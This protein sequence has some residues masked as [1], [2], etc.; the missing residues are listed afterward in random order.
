MKISM[1]ITHEE[2]KKMKF[3]WFS[4]NTLRWL[5]K[6]IPIVMICG[7]IYPS[8]AL[9]AEKS[10]IRI[11][12]LANRG[13]KL[14]T[15]MWNPTA[16][17]LSKEIPDVI[18]NIVPLL[19]EEIQSAVSK[20]EIDFILTNPANYVGL[21]IHHG[22]TRISTLKRMSPQ[23][24]TMYYGGVIIYKAGRTDLKFLKDLK[25][26]SFI[27]TNMDSFGG[28]LAICLELKE[29]GIDPF[30]FFSSIQF[31]NSH[32][33][34]I[35]AIKNGQAD[36]GGLRT[37]VLEDLTQKGIIHLNDFEFI[38]DHKDTGNELPFI[39]STRAYPEWA[40]AKLPHVQNDLGEKVAIALMRMPP[41][42][43]A[44][45]AAGCA[46]W[47]IPQNYQ[48]VHE[49]LKKLQ[50]EPYENFGKVSLHDLIERY[51]LLILVG[52]AILAGIIIFAG[53]TYRLNKKLQVSLTRE[54][55]L[56]AIVN[57]AEDAIIGI[58]KDGTIE[59]C[60]PA[61]FRMF[62]FTDNQL[63]GTQ[64]SMRLSHKEDWDLFSQVF[65]G[66]PFSRYETEMITSDN[67]YLPVSLTV[68]PIKDASGVIIGASIIARDI[69][70]RKQS[71]KLLHKTN[72]AL[73][74]LSLSN[75]A[76][77]YV[78]NEQNLL[79]TI[80]NIIVETGKYRMARVGYIDVTHG[81]RRIRNVTF[82]GHNDGYIEE[83][84]SSAISPEKGFGPSGIAIQTGKPYIVRNI[85]DDP[86]FAP[87]REAALKRGYRSV[88]ALPLQDSIGAFGVLTIYSEEPDAF[89]DSEYRLLQDLANN[90]SFGIRAIR[91]ASEHKKAEEGLKRLEAAIEQSDDGI[92]IT[93][94][95]GT[96]VYVNPAFERISGYSKQE[97]IGQNPRILKSNKQS[98]EFYKTMWD[99]ITQ[100]KVWRSRYTNK[101]KDGQLYETETS[102]SP[103]FDDSGKIINYVSVSRDITQEIMMEA[104]LRQ[105]QKMEAIGTL[106]GGIAHDF[107]NIL[108]PIFGYAQMTLDYLPPNSVAKKNLEKLLIAAKRAKDLVQQ[109]LTF[110]RK[111]EQSRQP[112]KI[113]FILKESLKLLRSVIPKTISI[114]ETIDTSCRPV[115][116]DA[117]QIH[118]VILNLCTNAYHAMRDKGGVLSVS[119]REVMLNPEDLATKPGLTPGPYVRLSI[120]DTG[121]GIDPAI[122]DKIFDPFFTTKPPGEGTGM[123][124]SVA[125]GIVKSHNG[126]ISVYSEYGIGSTFS[127]YL[128]CI[129]TSVHP[130]KADQAVELFRGSASIMIVD[131]EESIVEML[132]E[133]LEKRGFQ[134][135]A[136]TSS[137]EALAIFQQSPD[138]FDIVISDQTMPEMTGIQLVQNLLKIKPDLPIILCTGFSESI[139]E[140]QVKSMGVR[141]FIMKPVIVEDIIRAIKKALLKPANQPGK[142]P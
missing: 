19:Y 111:D 65:E 40:F 72:R 79:E 47:T 103:V 142:D 128:P 119:F 61:G 118:Q 25:Q 73:M 21:E 4:T 6:I 44:S 95:Q 8:D 46:G 30:K 42:S 77:I 94:A 57:S 33:E 122:K 17:Y 5:Y 16:E 54:S 31:V 39:H 7:L 100:G 137:L 52:F 89:D 113:Q 120:S 124:L 139:T 126:F 117:T 23:G 76:L 85:L 2:V 104:Q 9:L 115:M 63:L 90:L 24:P 109:I 86:N 70:L 66:L 135:T 98:P 141:E 87:W 3:F 49:C 83:I 88:I 60:N 130:Q 136:C 53:Y 26:K 116:G 48:P 138:R 14:C 102:I 67:K 74:V 129:D 62:G 91:T 110:S 43:L 82:A 97:A 36:I 69:T 37:G 131:D 45:K 123:G 114:R 84:Y 64:I 101:R 34:V 75:R 13:I 133:I 99:T 106:A 140:E 11:G 56:A 132:K 18:F 108:F 92:I 50:V 58:K 20:K 12:V 134:V 78:D 41:D 81:E 38:H 105:A 107:N 59:S 32:D 15:E 112:I 80:C 121:H 28:W 96:I 51:L 27:G 125:H 55:R 71:E 93:D 68:S 127:V 1:L 10:V 22:V 29:K 35:F